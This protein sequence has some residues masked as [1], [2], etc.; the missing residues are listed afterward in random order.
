MPVGEYSVKIDSP[1]HATSFSDPVEVKKGEETITKIVMG[2]GGSISGCV[3]RQ[4]DNTPV[5]DYSITIENRR[6]KMQ[7]RYSSRVSRS[8]DGKFEFTGLPAGIYGIT[9]EGEDFITCEMYWGT[10]EAGERKKR[11][12]YVDE[13]CTVSGH[14]YQKSDMSPV[15]TF[16]LTLETV[17]PKRK[18]TIRNVRFF[19]N[20]GSYQF[21]NVPSGTYRITV[22]ARGLPDTT[23]GPFDV[24]PE[25]G[26]VKDIYILSGGTVK[27]KVVDEHMLGIEGVTVEVTGLHERDSIENEDPTF[28]YK[29]KT[30]EIGAFVFKGLKPQKTNL[31]AAHP[32]YSDHS[33]YVMVPPDG[34]TVEV[35][36]KLEKGIK[37][38]GTIIA[39]D[40]NL[41]GGAKVQIDCQSRDASQTTMTDE[42]GSYVFN[43]VPSGRYR[44]H[45]IHEGVPVYAPEF[46]ISGESDKEINLNLSECG[47]ISGNVSLPSIEG[48]R[49][50]SVWADMYDHLK[51]RTIT[52]KRRTRVDEDGT[53]KID[54]LLPG[55]YQIR[56][57]GFITNEYG[58]R[59]IIYLS[60]VPDI[61]QVILSPT[62][63]VIKDITIIEI[64]KPE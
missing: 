40:G 9:V 31:K 2:P 12:I 6:S 47:S 26:N 49:T 61:I 42:T 13:G 30:D 27:G 58:R 14:V 48:N 11:D 52:R 20:D 7:V 41:L 36:L 53:Y 54:M 5:S 64:S 56:A 60:T 23:V 59:H 37:V 1:E 19:S 62:E 10:L 24:L 44:L 43:K 55:M 45:V 32:D 25:K 22:I 28:A 51:Q 39:P 8:T 38:Y 46:E 35:I 29:T 21:P 18:T 63:D 15:K 3:Y 17:P 33:E 57:S 34:E 50:Y 4:S 16:F